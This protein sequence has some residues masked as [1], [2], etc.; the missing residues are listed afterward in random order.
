MIRF[1]VGE[2]YGPERA[3]QLKILLRV[4]LGMVVLILGWGVLILV[5]HGSTSTAVRV[6]VLPGVLLGALAVGGLRAVAAGD[7]RAR[8]WVVATG[9]V[10]VLVA[11][12][13]SRTGVGLLVAVVGVPLLLIGALP[14]RDEQPKPPAGR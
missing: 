14:G 1:A 6:L 13:L 4:V 5:G 7:P 10:A 2:S 9:I 11:L 12:L 3:G 8:P